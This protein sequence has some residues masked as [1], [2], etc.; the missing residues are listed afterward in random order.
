MELTNKLKIANAI[1]ESKIPDI[2]K[3]VALKT[4]KNLN[5]DELNVWIKSESLTEGLDKPIR[6]A[7]KWGTA[8]VIGAVGVNAMRKRLS[9][10]V[11]NCRNVFKSTGDKAMYGKCV[12]KCNEKQ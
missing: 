10:C 4:I 5:E 11:S 2:E 7:L 12:Q 9:P 8:G 3:I 1:Y 6:T